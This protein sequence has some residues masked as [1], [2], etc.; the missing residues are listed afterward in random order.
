MSK[1]II[2][3]NRLPVTIRSDHREVAIERS[4]GGLA[5]G[6]NALHEQSDS[7]WVGW[8]G[9][10]SRF[11]MSARAEIEKR[12]SNIR[13][14]PVY[15]TQTEITR[16]YEGFSNGVL[17]PLFHY[18]TDKVERDAWR[19]WKSYAQV[20]QKFA[21]AVASHYKPGDLV[22]VHDFQLALVPGLLREMIADA[23]I[24]FFLHIPFPSSE[25]FRILPWREE[26]LRG[27]LGAD[28]IG[29]HTSSYLHHFLRALKHV[30][31][32]DSDGETVR[33]GDRKIDIGVFPMGVDADHFDRLAQD[34]DVVAEVKAIRQKAGGRK[35][36]LGVDR[37]DYTK[38]LAR[39]MLTIER[40]FERN[41]SLRNKV[42]LVQ[43]VAPS[44][45]KVPSYERLRRRLDETVGRINGTYSTVDAAPI[46]YLYRSLSERHLVALYRAAD[47]MLVTP[48]RDGMNLVAKEFVASRAD[49][50]G[51]LILSEFAGA[52]AELTE[53]IQVNPYDLDRTAS[54]IEQALSMPDEERR[55][56]MWALRRRVENHNCYRWADSFIDALGS[57]GRE[58]AVDSPGFS[59]GDEIEGVTKEIQDSRGLLLLLDYDGTL[60]PFASKP[61]LAAPDQE[62]KVLLRNLAERPHTSVHLLSGRTRS[63]LEQWFGD[64]PIGLHAEHGFWSWSQPGQSWNP[65]LV[66]S[67][68]W[69]EKVL[70][71]LEDFVVKTPG[72]LIEEK[73]IGFAWHYRLAD[74]E[75]GAVNA[76]RLRLRLEEELQ[77]LP[78][79]VLTGAKVIE[80]RLQ[81]V[82]KGV[83]ASRLISREQGEPTVLAMG[84]DTT[85]EDLF[86]ALPEGAIAVHIGPRVSIAR[87][88]VEDW[89]AARK[90]LA[91]ILEVAPQNAGESQSA[92]VSV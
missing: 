54:A 17:W 77:G 92:A 32:L 88:R 68:E 8:P 58:V 44:R 48:L 52:A 6:M 16:Y 1:L 23:R 72:A 9:D 63:E 57:A 12:L 7:L 84:D 89:A 76:E 41:P 65:L 35:L 71:V 86:A 10:V 83:I 40:L 18:S 31:G 78:I 61:E 20:N 27:M 51:A 2:V 56:R 82:N 50:D 75:L 74:S 29:F 49:E 55:A 60:V 36:L 64:L 33:D 24:G 46:H 90:L 22:W 43:V 11:D 34:A 45:T 87:Y 42:R 53:A 26:I 59:S 15:L 66:A 4:T 81:G 30:L 85:D 39:R 91:G 19:N 25:V 38:G 73:A 70:P 37:L 13:A 3:S 67:F 14:V 21:R 69:K 62:L 80:V 28:L 79:E 5:T 47:C